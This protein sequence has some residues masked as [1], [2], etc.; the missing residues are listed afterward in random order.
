MANTTQRTERQDIHIDH[1]LTAAILSPRLFV[2]NL[3]ARWGL[4]PSWRY[5]SGA[6][7]VGHVL[8]CRR[9]DLLLL[10]LLGLLAAKHCMTYPI[11][12]IE[13]KQDVSTAFYYCHGKSIK[14]IYNRV[15]AAPPK[16]F[17]PWLLWAKTLLKTNKILLLSA[18]NL[19]SF[20]PKCS[21][22]SLASLCVYTVE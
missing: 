9:C 21:Y 14:D 6:K 18:F 12:Y 22:W 2:L 13:C 11:Q 5:V 17:S 8:K 7:Y 15:T 10:W 20:V 3:E 1:I 16:R 19:Y 4:E